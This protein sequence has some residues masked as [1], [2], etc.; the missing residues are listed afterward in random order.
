MAEENLGGGRLERRAPAGPGGLAESAKPTPRQRMELELSGL[1]RAPDRGG[2][3]GFRHPQTAAVR[4][5]AG[6]QVRSGQRIRI[7]SQRDIEIPACRRVGAQG[8]VASARIH[9]VVWRLRRER[10]RRVVPWW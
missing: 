2:L 3:C 1:E 6:K 10:E 8:S 7:L 4:Y 5:E 9:L